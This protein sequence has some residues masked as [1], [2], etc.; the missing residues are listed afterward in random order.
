MK[1]LSLYS[2]SKPKEIIAGL[3]LGFMAFVLC[4][5]LAII[6]I[7]YSPS[8]YMSAYQKGCVNSNYDIDSDNFVSYYTAIT[9]FINSNDV[10]IVKD[11]SFRVNGQ[12]INMFTDS[13]IVL[14]ESAADFFVVVRCLAVISA[15]V[16]AGILVLVALYKGK[17]GISKVSTWALPCFLACGL[18]IF[19][20]LYICY[21]SGNDISY[22]VYNIFTL[23][24]LNA[25]SFGN[26]HL[27]Y[28]TV[29]MQVF[30]DAVIKIAI[31]FYFVLVLIIFSLC[32]I[33][34]KKKRDDNEDFMYQ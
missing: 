30:T 18:L 25:Y 17:M 29:T 32:N 21:L 10:E 20:F 22:L 13:D 24:A 12:I 9:E 16:I 26:L 28:G 4:A 27:F 23:K 15:V 31:M 2:E 5:C 8:V 34:F 33:A 3:L 14:L 11:A 7:V 1:F 6:A 19:L